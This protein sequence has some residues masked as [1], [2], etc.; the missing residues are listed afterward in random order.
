MPRTRARRTP[1]GLIAAALVA[2][3]VP[4]TAVIPQSQAIDTAPP[5]VPV[6]ARASVVPKAPVFSAAIDGASDYQAQSQC[7]PAPKPGA[8]KLARLITATYGRTPIGIA[9]SCSIGGLS[10]HKEGRALDWMVSMRVPS[11]RA[12]AESFLTWLLATDQYGNAA[13]MAKRLGIMYIGWNNLFWR[14]YDS[15]RGW[16]ELKGCLTD[17][18]KKAAGYDTYCHRNHVHLSL[19]WEGAS[20]LTSYWTGKPLAP[21]CDSPWSYGQPTP[22]AGADLV[23]VTPVRVLDSRAGIGV[24]AGALAAPCRLG[25]ARWSGDRRDLVVTVAGRGEVPPTG[26]AAVAIRVTVARTSAPTPTVSARA[27][28]AGALVP[29]VSPLTAS[30]FAGTAVVPVAAD[31]TVRL[32]LDRGTAEVTVDVLAWAAPVVTA[33]APPVPTPDTPTPPAA[34][35]APGRTH[36]V[37]PVTVYDGTA[38]PLAPGEVRTVR[39]AGLGGIPATGVQGLVLALTTARTTTSDWIGVQAGASG[40]YVAVL[41]SSTT[42]V[43]A[44]HGV[45]PTKDGVVTVR[46][47]GK[48]PAVIQLRLHA[49]I[50]DAADTGGSQLTLLP[51][52]VLLVDSARKIGLV[53][54][55]TTAKARA[56]TVT[57]G[58]VPV[59]AQAVLVSVSGL[60]G[61]TESTFS[62]ASRGSARVANLTPG[63]W[64]H[65]VLLLS[66]LPSGVIAVS[67]P[68]LGSQVR[69]SVLG[70]V[71]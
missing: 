49:W 46:N 56:V 54:P 27:T 65:D 29:V 66:L 31:G 7:T 68:S 13:A 53:G 16:T 9:R 60:G 44:T 47:A 42:G 17:P 70:Y 39:L 8:L 40:P 25:T 19:S 62:L 1:V 33:P 41:R 45:V 11:Q 14:G 10:E 38:T 35:A 12:Q 34:A 36:V 71:A 22:V 2:A 30:A 64:D 43:R 48:S 59:G 23:P 63:R 4:L 6:A 69:I 20:G 32:V 21:T 52:P 55:V 15:G 67:S 26:V 61:T 51:S 37:S 24:T 28:A 57:G 18:R 58:R 50:G 3:L 5:V